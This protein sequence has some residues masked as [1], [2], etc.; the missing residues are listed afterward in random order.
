M[1]RAQLPLCVAQIWLLCLCHGVGTRW[2][3]AYGIEGPLG[4][5]EPWAIRSCRGVAE[6]GMYVTR[7][8]MHTLAKSFLG[9]RHLLLS[10]LVSCILFLVRI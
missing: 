6:V 3:Y 9:Y 10:V 4:W 1:A 7:E 2:P 8:T 5:L